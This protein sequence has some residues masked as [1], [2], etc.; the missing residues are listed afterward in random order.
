VTRMN[1]DRLFYTER[2]VLQKLKMGMSPWETGLGLPGADNSMMAIAPIGIINA[3][4]PRQA[5]VDGFAIGSMMSAGFDRDACATIAAAVAASFCPRATVGTITDAM[6]QFSTPLVRRSLDRVLDLAAKT[7]TMDD[8]VDRFHLEMLDW[9]YPSPPKE[10]WSPR[11]FSAASIESFPAVVGILNMMQGEAWETI[12][13]GASF[14]RD[15]DTIAAVLGNITGALHGVSALPVE[16]VE[17]V[18]RS[19]ED[20]Y[21]EAS[22]D[23]KR[24]FAVIAQQLVDA[25][26]VECN[27]SREH[28]DLLRTLLV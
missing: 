19:N 27:R 21:L 1:P 28:A 15:C 9:T 8:F 5:Y 11:T 13:S 20:F 17:Q 18:E 22:G 16:L 14:G 7:K 6:R 10:R 12:V 4:N 25:L 26:E 24:N 2:I 3:G 23:P